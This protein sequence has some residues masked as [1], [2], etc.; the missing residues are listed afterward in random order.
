M[1]EET[2]VADEE[3]AADAEQLAEAGLEDIDLSGLDDEPAAEPAEA[4]AEE[5]GDDDLALAEVLAEEPA[6]ED[7]V[8]QEAVAEEEPSAEEASTE[9][10]VAAEEPA[11]EEELDLSALEEEPIASEEAIPEEAIAEEEP[12]A[13]EAVALEAEA[14]EA[15]AIVDEQVAAP[16]QEDASEADLESSIEQSI[17]EEK[18]FL[19][20]EEDDPNEQ[21]REQIAA[22]AIEIPE[23][24]D[25][26]V[27]LRPSSGEAG[28]KLLTKIC[29]PDATTV[30]IEFGDELKVELDMIELK[31]R[32]S[33]VT[34]Q[35]KQIAF[36]H[37]PGEIMLSVDGFTVVIAKDAAA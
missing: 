32:E 31:D 9:E 33:P 24:P 25:N 28:D 30:C 12:S 4:S 36:D 10:A 29:M 22:G 16:E 2:P 14:P 21:A 6:A 26:V 27:A 11:A 7:A 13:E 20:Q 17:D 37:R 35:G 15:E 8:A 18:T 34:L 5:G 3:L 23:E 19:D 1:A